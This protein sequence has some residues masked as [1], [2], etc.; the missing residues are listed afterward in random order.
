MSKSFYPIIMTDNLNESINFYEDYLGFVAETEMNCFA[1][2]KHKKN[3]DVRLGLITKN[4]HSLPEH[5]QKNS[6]GLVLNFPVESVNEVY[7]ELY[8]EGLEIE[9]EPSLAPCGRRHF[10][11]QDPNGVLIDVM[12]EYDP[13][14]GQ[15][16]NSEEFEV[17]MQSIRTH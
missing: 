17:M 6:Q 13:F 3:D 15:N 2:L 5:S 7:R 11:I 12:E 14:S 9:N 8:M 1:V 4:H 16:D 10:M